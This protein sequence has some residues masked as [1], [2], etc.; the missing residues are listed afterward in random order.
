MGHHVL[1]GALFFHIV[2]DLR[3]AVRLSLLV[4]AGISYN[5]F[6]VHHTVD[7]LIGI[8]EGSLTMVFSVN[9]LSLGDDDLLT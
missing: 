6:A 4:T 5:W 1:R 2:L 3:Q 9:F 7:L 8:R